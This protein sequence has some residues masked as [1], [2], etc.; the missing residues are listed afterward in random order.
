MKNRYPGICCVCGANVPAGKGDFELVN[1]NQ[2]PKTYENVVGRW[3]IR[4]R[5]CKGKGHPADT[6]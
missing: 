4:C 3:A 5:R 2:F 1:R 6:Q